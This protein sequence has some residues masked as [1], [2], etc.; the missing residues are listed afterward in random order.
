MNEFLD[1]FM[2]H[3][4]LSGTFLLILVAYIGFEF[5]QKTNTKEVTPEQVVDLFNHQHALIW[6]VRSEGEFNTGHIVGAQNVVMHDIE[7]NSKK[8]QKY[9]QKPVVLVCAA[10]KRSLQCL[11]HLEAQGFTQVVS[12]AGGLHAW[13]ASGLPLTKD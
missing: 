5:M 7:T 10:G 6:D 11:K 12:L 2:L 3:W 8:L 13:Q 1:F 9:A 4:Q